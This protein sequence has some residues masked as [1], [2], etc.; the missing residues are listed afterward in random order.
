MTCPLSSSWLHLISPVNDFILLRGKKIITFEIIGTFFFTVCFFGGNNLMKCF[1]VLSLLPGCSVG[2]I[3]LSAQ[4][5]CR[6]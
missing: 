2:S 3:K 6:G 5:R 1:P 4:G